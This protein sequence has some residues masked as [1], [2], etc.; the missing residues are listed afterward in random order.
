MGTK[1]VKDQPFCTKEETAFCHFMLTRDAQG[2]IRTYKECAKLAGIPEDE[3]DKL[4][5]SARVKNYCQKFSDQ[6]AIEMAIHEADHRAD[7]ELTPLNVAVKLYLAAPR[8]K[9]ER[10]MVAAYS[11][12]LD[13]FGPLDGRLKT[14]TIEDINYFNEHRHWPE[15]RLLHEAK[16]LPVP[17]PSPAPAVPVSDGEYDF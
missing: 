17:K 12:L 15:E 11:R 3:A 2:K 7:A 1:G 4:A 13:W 10:A 8:M 14:A 6:L 16:A 9:D 5:L